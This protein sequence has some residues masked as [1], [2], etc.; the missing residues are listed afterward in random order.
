MLDKD[1]EKNMKIMSKIHKGTICI[2]TIMRVFR[3]YY[4]NIEFLNT[5]YFNIRK[6][7][8]CLSINSIN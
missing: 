6:I 1:F 7:I 4:N 3:V 2:P 8:C 5:T